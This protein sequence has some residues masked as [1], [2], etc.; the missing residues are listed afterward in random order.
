MS[1]R[2]WGLQPSGDVSTV[3][4][5]ISYG[6]VI[7]LACGGNLLGYGDESVWALRGNA[8]GEHR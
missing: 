3:A 5:K 8:L 6:R 7:D 1:K 4:E 2:R